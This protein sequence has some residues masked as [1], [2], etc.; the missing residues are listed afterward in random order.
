MRTIYFILCAGLL[1]TGCRSI[2]EINRDEIE[3]VKWVK[4]T[5]R[6]TTVVI[7]RDSAWLRAWLACDSSGQVMIRELMDYQQGKNVGL[8]RIN[9]R[10]NLLTAKV[11]VDSFGIFMT[12][13]DKYESHRTQQI[14]AIEKVKEVYRLREWQKWLLGWG[15]VSLLIILRKLWKSF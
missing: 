15:V 14:T 8:P 13:R 12:L 4:E 5:V 10:N 1:V 2:K 7:A 11:S 3:T 6:D 9:I